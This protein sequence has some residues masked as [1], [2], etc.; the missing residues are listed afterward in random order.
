MESKIQE[1]IAIELINTAQ[2]TEMI[3]LLSRNKEHLTNG[4]Y[5]YGLFQAEF[6]KETGNYY[7]SFDTVLDFGEEQLKEREQNQLNDSL[8]QYLTK[9]KKANL[10]NDQQ[11]SEQS[12]RIKN[13]QYVHLFQLVL[14]LNNQVNFDEWMSFKKL[15][16]FRKELLE[17]GVINQKEND[18][19]RSDI[20]DKKIQSPFQLI[21]YCQKARF[22]DLSKYANDPKTYLEQIHKTTSQILPELHFTDFR[23]EIKVD[24]AASFRNH[25][26]HKL[27][28]SLTSN[29][30]TYKQK[31]FI[32]PDTIGQD[33]NFLGKIDNQQYYHIFNKILKDTQSPYRLHLISSTHDYRQTNSHQYFGIVALKKGQLPMFRYADSYWNLSY[34]SFK[35][36][37][38]SQTIEHALKE[39]QKL[40]L[41]D[42][43][44]KDQISNAIQTVYE[45]QNTN[46]NDVL[47]SFPQIIM[48]F[49]LELGNLENPYEE[50]VTEYAKISHQEFNPTNI[51]DDFDIDK[52]TVSVSFDF[53]NQHHETEFKVDGDW[54]DTRLFEY[55][56]QVIQE[57]KSKGKFYSLY[58]DAAEFIY[59]TTQTIQI[60]YR[61]QTFGILRRMPK[62]NRRITI[63][64]LLYNSYDLFL[65]VTTG[66]GL[67]VPIPRPS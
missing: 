34:E 47:I 65:G 16:K 26:S 18:L 10:I 24:T 50:I 21:D 25:I 20:K 44:E 57:S 28:T 23:F 60:H 63:H 39:Y 35:N 15:D 22:F 11:F 43:L 12:N 59:L 38:T 14:D 30:I 42:H 1:L 33:N 55:I 61:K 52:P 48:S 67:S 49:D 13:N 53:N 36:P 45:K 31:S 56:N 66:V 29:G 2:A 41:F 62:P 5:L 7:S 40:G 37:L 6:K 19:L 9:V 4:Q 64:T 17:S 8:L 51:H 27:V 46:L 3:E 32:V 54:I 58:G